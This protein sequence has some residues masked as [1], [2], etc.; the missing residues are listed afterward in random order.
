M[1]NGGRHPCLPSL[2]TIARTP[3]G[4]LQKISCR[5]KYLERMGNLAVCVVFRR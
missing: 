5:R 2:L 4:E 1:L 3:D